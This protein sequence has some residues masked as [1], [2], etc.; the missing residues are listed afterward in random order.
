MDP[1]DVYAVGCVAGGP[2]Q[3]VD[4]AVVALLADGRLRVERPGNCR[5][6]SCG[7][8]TPSRP[9]SLTPSIGEPAGRWRPCATGAVRTS[10]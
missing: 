8:A 6:P 10:G 1:T 5:R 9:R 4:T 3:A 2:D 7:T